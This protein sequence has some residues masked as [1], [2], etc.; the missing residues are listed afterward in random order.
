[1]VGQNW[2]RRE[3]ASNVVPSLSLTL[4]I[5][6]KDS[7]LTPARFLLCSIANQLTVPRISAKQYHVYVFCKKPPAPPSH[8][9][10]KLGCTSL[11]QHGVGKDCIR[12]GCLPGFCHPFS[13]CLRNPRDASCLKGLTKGAPESSY[14]PSSIYQ[15]G[16]LT[17]TWQPLGPALDPLGLLGPRNGAVIGTRIWALL[18]K[19]SIFMCGEKE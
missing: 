5:T 11:D 2:V 3:T 16:S 18:P 17:S 7:F 10:I 15:T 6:D 4:V 14:P 12:V 13:S 19:V 8:F 9:F 1:M